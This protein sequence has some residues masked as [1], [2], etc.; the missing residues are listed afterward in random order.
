MQ[1]KRKL[2]SFE[3]NLL[4]KK[5]IDPFSLE[6]EKLGDMPVEYFI[7]EA[8]FFGREFYV[9]SNVLIPR[10]ETEFLIKYALEYIE[11]NKLS[12]I[13]FLDVGTGSGC[14]GI[15]F[16]IE[17]FRRKIKFN[18]ELLDISDEALKVAF[19][20]A[21]NHFFDRAYKD[22][23]KELVI[24][25]GS[26]ISIK[27]SDLV[28]GSVLDNVDII[29][30][31]LPYIPTERIDDLSDSVRNYEPI[32]ALDG[33][34]DGFSAIDKLITMILAREIKSA[35]VLFEVDDTHDES[36]LSKK[37][38]LSRLNIKILNDENGKNRYWIWDLA[39]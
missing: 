20:N 9:D 3:M 18:A 4:I 12:K 1:T 33:G 36:F 32:L 39:S 25:D 17:L 8:E 31:N 21:K 26:N 34:I 13:N 35:L 14:I 29:F 37:T 16:A 11:K 6:I 23:E 28:G 38:A 22:S 10:V 15:T 24:Y 30:A 7:N 5:G 2:N 19:K 27:K